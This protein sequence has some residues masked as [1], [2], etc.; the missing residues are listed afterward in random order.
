MYIFPP[1]FRDVGKPNF[2]FLI[3]V[4]NA[5]VKDQLTYG[6]AKL[7]LERGRGL[8]DVSAIELTAARGRGL[9]VC[10]GVRRSVELEICAKRER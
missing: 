10:F 1:K 6:V 3:R 8:L 5:R 9:A 7:S 4:G 2:E